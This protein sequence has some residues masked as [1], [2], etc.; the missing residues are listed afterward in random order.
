MVRFTKMTNSHIRNVIEIEKKSFSIPWNENM[1][2]EEINNSIAYYCVMKYFFKIIGYA[3]VWI[4]FDEGHITN[5]AIDPKFRRK[6]YGKR[7]LKH[8]IKVLT[9]RGISRITLEVRKSN[10]DAIKLY[11]KFDFYES[12]I[13]KKYY[14]DNKEDAIIMW[15][16]T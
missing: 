16:I 11:K 4:I 13:R 14:S 2:M 15:R 9:K 7:I 5:L 3:G 1:Y 6:G 8:L 12:G 10:E